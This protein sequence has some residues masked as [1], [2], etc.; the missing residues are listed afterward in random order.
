MPFPAIDPVAFSIGPVDIRWYALAY[1]AGFLAGWRLLRGLVARF[2]AGATARDVDDLLPWAVL[3]VIAGGRLGYVLFYGSG[4]LLS[5]PLAALAVWRGGMSFHGGAAGLG[6]AVWLFCRRR[7]LR[8]LPFADALSSVVPIGL[9]LGRLANFV[10]GELWGRATSLPWGVVFPDAGPWPRHPSQLYEA[11]LE[12][13]LLFALLQ[14]LVRRTGIAARPGAVSGV[15][16]AGY[17]GA[18]IIVEFVREPDAHLGFLAGPLTMGMLLSLP[19][20]GLGALLWARA[21]RAP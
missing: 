7:G 20:L 17:A 2:P 12:G 13:V 8:F 3:G 15:F 19:M 14:A 1:V 21:R 5:D 4:A 6:I 16:L 10:N 11:A 9:F 18:R